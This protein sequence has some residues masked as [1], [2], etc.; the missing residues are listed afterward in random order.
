MSSQA[1]SDGGGGIRNDC[2]IDFHNVF[3]DNDLLRCFQDLPAPSNAVFRHRFRHGQHELRH[4]SSVDKHEC[5][6]LD[7]GSQFVRFRI[8][9][10]RSPVEGLHLSVRVQLGQRL[11]QRQTSSFRNPR[12]SATTA[13]QRVRTGA[14]LMEL[15]FTAA[16]R[17]SISRDAGS[18]TRSSPKVS[19]QIRTWHAFPFNA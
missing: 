10:A 1:V 4:R 11:A 5:N 16:P 12:R 7:P 17:G 9:S 2:I 3:S 19:I 8:D 14:R 15:V 6:A 18:Y 13:A